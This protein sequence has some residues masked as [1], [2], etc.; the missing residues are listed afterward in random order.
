MNNTN[1]LLKIDKKQANLNFIEFK[2]N[3]FYEKYKLKNI[4]SKKNQAKLHK[5]LKK[6]LLKDK[7]LDLTKEIN[8][9]YKRKNFIKYTFDNLKRQLNNFNI[10]GDRNETLL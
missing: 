2:I 1:I 8:K 6:R 3:H 4:L 5:F 7:T 10:F 9:F